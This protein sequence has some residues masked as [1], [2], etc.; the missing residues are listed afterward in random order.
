MFFLYILKVLAIFFI[1]NFIFLLVHFPWLQTK[2]MIFET[3]QSLLI[4]LRYLILLL[5]ALFYLFLWSVFWEYSK[6]YILSFP[7]C[8]QNFF[9]LYFKKQIYS[10]KLFN[11]INLK[12]LNFCWTMHGFRLFLQ[13]WLSVL[14]GLVFIFFNP[15]FPTLYLPFIPFHFV[16]WFFVMQTYYFVN[17]NLKKSI[18]FFLI[19][20]LGLFMISII[21]FLGFI[22]HVIRFIASF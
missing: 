4:D 20:I 22:F 12:N 15:D 7:S 13:Y 8:L 17:S 16:F 14:F 21:L 6:I 5:P 9:Y 11:L 2:L 1:G 3:F 19:T 18:F 10:D